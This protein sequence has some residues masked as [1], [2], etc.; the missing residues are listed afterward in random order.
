MAQETTDFGT[1]LEP[2]PDPGDFLVWQMY[3][4]FEFFFSTEFSKH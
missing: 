1:D 2:N 4:L 3:A